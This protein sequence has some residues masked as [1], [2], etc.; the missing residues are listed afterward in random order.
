MDY[1]GLL[2]DPVY[3]ALGVP[4][5]L[6]MG[7]AG[8]FALTVIDNTRAKSNTTTASSGVDVR[9]VRAGAFV[10]VPELMQNGISPDQYRGSILTFNGRSWIVQ[11]HEMSGSP[12]GEDLGQ[13]LLLLRPV[14]G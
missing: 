7:T 10:R 1:S 11:N 3:A 2:Y 8:E 6:S 12:N 4:A 13:V 5:T 14:D 9:S